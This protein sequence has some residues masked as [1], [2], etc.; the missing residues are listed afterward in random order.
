M[1]KCVFSLSFFK[2]PVNWNNSLN[3]AWYFLKKADAVTSC[4]QIYLF[5]LCHTRNCHIVQ[6]PNKLIISLIKT[7][8][9]ELNWLWIQKLV[10]VYV[11]IPILVAFLFSFQ[12]NWMF[13]DYQFRTLFFIHMIYV[14]YKSTKTK[15]EQRLV[16]CRKHLPISTWPSIIG[17]WSKSVFLY[18]ENATNRLMIKHL[19]HF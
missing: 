13:I 11:R 4:L 8:Y 2:R 14:F 10:L 1:S 16:I 6:Y 5:F 7:K 18:D 9:H 3:I 17:L 12:R 15:A 19:Y